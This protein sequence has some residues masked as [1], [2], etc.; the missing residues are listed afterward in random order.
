MGKHKLID[1]SQCTVDVAKKDTVKI[2]NIGRICKTHTD[3]IHQYFPPKAR[4]LSPKQKNQAMVDNNIAREKKKKE[5][6]E[7]KERNR[8]IL[9]D[10]AE[11]EAMDKEAEKSVIELTKQIRVQA[12][13][14]GKRPQEAKEDIKRKLLQGGLDKDNSIYLLELLDRAYNKAVSL[15]PLTNM[16]ITRARNDKP[17]DR[18]KEKADKKK[19]R[20]KSRK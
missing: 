15:G 11:Q 8:L 13:Q 20:K 14:S 1:C 10:H 7:R 16:E 12:R 9:L 5:E 18:K 3:I 6:A 4:P 2:P 19:K 17:R